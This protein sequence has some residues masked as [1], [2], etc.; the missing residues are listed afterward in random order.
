MPQPHQKRRRR[1]TGPNKAQQRE[2]AVRAQQMA[3]EPSPE[4]LGESIAVEEGTTEVVDL[5]ETPQAVPSPVGLR[6]PRTERASR[7]VR[8]DGKST[9]SGT[10]TSSRRRHETD[11]PRANA[12]PAPVAYVIPHE[13]EYAFIRADLRRLLITAGV[14]LV[15]ML[16]LLFLIEG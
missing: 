3:A 10:G 15:L 13:Q 6:P 2:A 5:A 9:A 1:T 14:V 4:L 16:A 8:A 11:M 7:S 12:T